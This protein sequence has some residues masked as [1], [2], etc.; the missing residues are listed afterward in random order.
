MSIEGDGLTL[1][2]RVLT[3]YAEHP[4]F[5]GI[6]IIGLGCE[7]NQVSSLLKKFEPK[8][9]QHIRT[10]VIQENGGTR[11]TIENVGKPIERIRKLHEKAQEIEKKRKNL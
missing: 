2:Q 4:N 11:K 9:R 8:D 5:A 7:V 10:L 1:L 3:G 6:L